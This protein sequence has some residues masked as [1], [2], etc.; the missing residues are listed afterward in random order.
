MLWLGDTV[1]LRLFT[2]QAALIAHTQ[3]HWLWVCFLAPASFL[4][5]Q[6][7][8]IF[9]GATRGQDMRDAMIISASGLGL[10]LIL[11]VSWDLNGLWQHL[12]D[13]WDFAAPAYG[14]ILAGYMHKQ[15]S[16]LNEANTKR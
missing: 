8:G 10:A 6:L 15:V 12:S 3:N 9:V 5:F 16:P 11:L 14:G 7:D 1:I 2:T 13:I 4:A